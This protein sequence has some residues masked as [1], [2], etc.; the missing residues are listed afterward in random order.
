MPLYPTFNTFLLNGNGPQSL[1]FGTLV[2]AGNNSPKIGKLYNFTLSNNTESAYV[3]ENGTY[4]TQS[5]GNAIYSYPEGGAEYG[6]RILT[7][8][9]QSENFITE[10]EMNTSSIPTGTTLSLNV[11]DD[12]FGQ[13]RGHRV[14]FGDVNYS[15]VPISNRN[16]TLGGTGSK[17]YTLSFSGKF[18]KRA[19]LRLRFNYNRIGG[20]GGIS[21][22]GDIV[23]Y[24]DKGRVKYSI[25][26]DTPSDFNTANLQTSPTTSS[27]QGI[28]NLN[29][30]ENLIGYFSDMQIEPLSY[31]S[32]NIPITDPS[33]SVPQNSMSYISSTDIGEIFPNGATGSIYM[34]LNVKNHG[35]QYYILNIR[36]TSNQLFVIYSNSENRLTS[37][38]YNGTTSVL[39][40]IADDYNHNTFVKII[41]TF[42]SDGANIYLG[43]RKILSDI[44][45][46]TT[47]TLDRVG[48]GSSSG[49]IAPNNFEIR[50]LG[51]SPRKISDYE[52]KNIFRY[53]TFDYMVE[54]MGYKVPIKVYC[55]EY[56][57]IINEGVANGFDLPTLR[58]Q[59]VHN[60]IVLLLIS[61]GIWDL[62]DVFYIFANNGGSGYASINWKNPS[63]Y[64]LQ[65]IDSPTF[66]TNK[67]FQGNGSS[68]YINTGYSPVD[69]GLLTINDASIGGYVDTD[70]SDT[71]ALAGT[72]IGSDYLSVFIEDVAVVNTDVNSNFSNGSPNGHGIIHAY[73]TSSS[74]HSRNVSG[75]IT[76]LS[77]TSTSLPD[78]YILVLARNTG[79][80]KN[81]LT[82]SNFSD[83]MVNAFWVGRG[84]INNTAFR[85][86]MDNYIKY[87]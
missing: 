15:G 21:L 45:F 43:D 28:V 17:T 29:N 34:D 64:L 73:R 58:Q 33:V 66:T 18:N 41:L 84:T 10:H 9:P 14:E 87:G 86:I 50:N 13:S 74:A 81:T 19:T 54:D 47:G 46:M 61:S 23:V 60:A 69:N 67:G 31:F 68:S 71:G 1:A 2:D 26:F 56:Q 38:Y 85:K 30:V 51:F 22:I 77:T 70:G 52:V 6:N 4:A 83:T 8:R 35:T 20:G 82:P 12:D 11:W 16:S 78:N 80:N 7:F 42:G 32:G 57:R 55:K 76:T 36:N 5:G 53:K 79:S 49:S 63:K 44:S 75:S 65:L 39:E 62:L 59:R 48:L 37:F 25:T 3:T 72:R 27:I 24:P 40:T